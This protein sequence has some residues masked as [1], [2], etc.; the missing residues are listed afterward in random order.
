MRALLLASRLVAV[1]VL[2]TALG[3]G[4]G[5]IKEAVL[6]PSAVSKEFRE[7]DS[8]NPF[9]RGKTR[10]A[11]TQSGLKKYDAFFSDAAE[12]K[13]TVILADVVLQ[14]TQKYIANMKKQLGRGK[15]LSSTNAAVVKRESA[16]MAALV[17]MLLGVPARAAK[18]VDD[19][20]VLVK[21]APATFLGPDIVKLPAVVKG[22]THATGDLRDAAVSAPGL[23]SRVKAM[24][25]TLTDLLP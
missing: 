5:G 17:G 4:C 22:I 20:Q 21:E 25:S 15:I 1:S 9:A 23:V 3:T 11:V 14:R 10:V 24:G 18:L 2:V 16:R 13:G 7:L 12:V 8:A 6:K 19:G